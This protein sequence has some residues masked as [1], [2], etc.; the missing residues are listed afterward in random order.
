MGYINS[1]AFSIENFLIGI[2][3]GCI[4]ANILWINEFPDYEADRDAGKRNLVVRLGTASA[5]Y[6]YVLLE[7]LFY[8]SVA[9]LV[10]LKIY[11]VWS[12][13][14]LLSLPAAIKTTNHLWKHHA[15][16]VAVVPAQAGTIKFQMLTAV[17]T[18]ISFVIDRFV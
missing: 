18:I 16:P 12:L 13:L 8:I 15:D 4:V 10:F 14:I 5:R 2:P 1:G 17:I 7:A 11:P 9:T 3:N 6:G